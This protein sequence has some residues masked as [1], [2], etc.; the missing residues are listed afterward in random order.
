MKAKAPKAP[1]ST[2]RSTGRSTDRSA[3]PGAGRVVLLVIGGVVAVIAIAGYMA[4]LKSSGEQ[5]ASDDRAA[6][7]QIG[8]ANDVDAK[9][10]AQQTVAA[11]QELYSEQGSFAAVT[12]ASLKHFEPTF[13]Y[14][15][16]ASTG[17]NVVSVGSS[18]NGVGLA[19][20]SASGTCF[21][22]HVTASG[23]TPGEGD[24]VDPCVGS[25]AMSISS[26]DR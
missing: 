10:T 19:V 3:R 24:K 6:V 15:D 22:T 21:Y 17:P 8:V 20:L 26:G 5:I 7:S 12:P 11:V 16:S 2:D 23:A 18:A 1:R 14:T 13:S 9:M 25:S 4:F